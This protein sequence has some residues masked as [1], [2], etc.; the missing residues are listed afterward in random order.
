RCVPKPQVCLTTFDKFGCSQ[1]ECVPRQLTCDQARDPVCDTD[2]MEHSNLCTLY[3]RGKS[4]SYRGPCQPFCRAKE[5]VCGHN[6]ETYS[7]VCAAYS[8]RVAVDYYGPCQAVGVLSEYSAVAE[9]AAVKCPSLSAIG[10]KPIIPPGACCP[11]C[12]G[13]LRVLFDKEKLDTIA[14]VTSK[15]PI[16]VVEILQKVRMHVSVPQCDVFGYLSI[17]SEIV[18]LIIPV[19]HYPKALQIEACNKEAEKIES[20]INSDSPTLASHVPL[21]ALIISQVQVSSSLP[22]SAVVGRPLFHSLLLLLSLGLTVHL[23]WTRP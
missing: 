21:S 19:D 9:C 12:A 10:C 3:Q 1:Y 7:S 23:L 14:K 4:L 20:L 15:K 6:G 13:M 2:H 22:S 5:P 8:D 18:I 11:L 17:E 16:T